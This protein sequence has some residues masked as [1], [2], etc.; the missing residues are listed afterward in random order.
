M[1]AAY[2]NG[3]NRRINKANDNFTIHYCNTC[4]NM[5]EF[6][7]V[8]IPYAYKLMAQELQTINVVPRIITE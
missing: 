6:A 2:Y 8:E 1:I 5:T 4:G 7:R 3:E